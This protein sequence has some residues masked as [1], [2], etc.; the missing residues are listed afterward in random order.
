MTD[1]PRRR[2]TDKVSGSPTFIG[3]GSIFTGDLQCEG[4]VV[5][6]GNA[7][8]D[9]IARGAFTLAAEARWE[10]RLQAKNAMIAGEVQ[11]SLMIAEKIEIRK[12]ARI[13][14]SVTA[15]SIAVAQ[16]ALIEGDLAVTS[17]AAVVRYEEK[18]GG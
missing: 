2:L 15:R 10:G 11:G 9:C 12:S 14:G 16:G 7:T 18:R 4:D 8:G 13:R 3:R 5:V 6:E 1:E 17:G